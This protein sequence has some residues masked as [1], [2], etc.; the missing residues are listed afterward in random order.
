MGMLC[1][2]MCS[3]CHQTAE[4]GTS[5]CTAHRDA[6]KVADK[7]RKAAN[8]LRVQFN[9]NSKAWRVTRQVTLFRFPLCAQVDECGARCPELATEAH[10]IVNAQVWVAQGGSYLDQDNLVGLCKACHSKHTAAERHGTV[11]AGSFAPEDMEASPA[12]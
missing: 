1:A 4:P 8:P 2:R 11:V 5:L 7:E 3:K 10:H 9:Y 6:D 12:I